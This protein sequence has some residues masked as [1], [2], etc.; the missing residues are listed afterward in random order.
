[1]RMLR[2]ETAPVARDTN[3][4]TPCGTNSEIWPD[5]RAIGSPTDFW[6]QRMRPSR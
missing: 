3:P 2:S 6:N 1:M 4:S 5:R